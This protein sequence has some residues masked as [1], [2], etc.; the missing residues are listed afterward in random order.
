MMKTKA[1]IIE[2]TYEEPLL[3]IFIPSKLENIFKTML[4]ED[5]EIPRFNDIKMNLPRPFWDGHDDVIELYYKAWEIAFGNLKKCGAGAVSNFIDAAFNEY[6]FLWD[7]AFM[8]LFGR[9]ADHIFCFQNTLNNFYCTQEEDGFIG[10]EISKASGKPR[11]HRFDPVSTGCNIF[12]WVEMIYYKQFKNKERLKNIFPVILAYHRWLKMHRTWKDGSYWS[13]GW[14]CGMDNQ[15][16]VSKEEYDYSFHDHR[17]W[18]D[19]CMQQVLS[20]KMLIQMKDILNIDEDIS[21]IELE[22]K[23]LTEFINKNLW[24]NETGFYYDALRNGDLDKNKSIGAY[25]AIIAEVASEEQVEQLVNK[26]KDKT[27]FMTQNPIPTMPKS[28][29]H[30]NEEGQYWR[31]GVWAPT[32]YM[33]LKGIE[34]Y[35]YNDLAFKIASLHLE[36]VNNVHKKTGTLWENYCPTKDER[37]N[38]SKPN[39]IGWSGLSPISMLIEFVLGIKIDCENNQILWHINLLEEHG[40]CNLPYMENNFI[41]LKCE[42]R[43]N[44]ND[45]PKVSVT[46]LKDG[47]VIIFWNGNEK[48]IFDT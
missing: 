36:S 3:D 7:S 29:P 35:G 9:Y 38:P 44:L 48:I 13:C 25:W 34:I 10:R 20:G 6:I 46:G 1:H 11:Y 27:E 21:D 15:L 16:R 37:G 28:N 42:A 5:T 2:R 31:G 18:T 32:N 45:E 12:A 4:K 47:K 14:A 33:V 43:N 40:I 39:F 22:C 23:Q 17:T 24:D 8:T 41:T 26:L 30:F 19:M